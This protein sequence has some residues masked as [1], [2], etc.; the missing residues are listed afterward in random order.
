MKKYKLLLIILCLLFSLFSNAQMGIGTN[1]PDASSILDLSSTTKGFLLPRMTSAEQLLLV[2]P[3]IG[4][5]IFNISSGQIESNKGDGLGGALWTGFTTSGDTAPT[6]TSTTQLA[7]TEFVMSNTNKYHSVSGVGPISTTSGSDLLVLGMTISPPGGTYFVN[8]NSQFNFTPSTT[9]I[10]GV[11]V[12]TNQAAMDLQTAYN[13]LNSLS[14][15]NSGHAA[16]FGNGETLTPGVYS[17]AAAASMAGTL[18]LDG[19]NDSNSKFV[20]KIGAAFNT[21]AGSTVLLTNGASACNVFWVVEA[22]VGLGAITKIKGTFISHGAALAAGA[23]CIIEGRL[24]STSGALTC[25]NLTLNVP[26]NC[27]FIDL[28]VTARFGMFTGTGA[29]AGTAISTITGDIGTNSIGPITGL[30]TA[31]VNGII[32]PPMGSILVTPEITAPSSGLAGFSI[33]Q[34]GVLIANSSR[35]RT[36]LVNPAEISLQAIATIAA[37]QSID[38]RW[39]TNTGILTLGN[40]ILTLLNVR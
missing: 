13:Q 21:G 10:P 20:F 38:I 23:G 29:I 16:V 19:Q 27:N 28:G 26:Q 22:A 18:T 24:L 2:N 6:G 4:L 7:T 12:S 9:T 36:S 34:N 32:F 1:T 25:D 3:A 33:Y 39:K 14:V 31:M 37:G 8:F 40:R 35:I 15:T 11:E 17:I 30:T 5:T